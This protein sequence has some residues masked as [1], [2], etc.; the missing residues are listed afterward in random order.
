MIE[1]FPKEL[2]NF[3]TISSNQSLTIKMLEKFPDKKWNWNNISFNKFIYH[4][5]SKK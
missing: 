2:W 5:K 1:L 4:N 3:H